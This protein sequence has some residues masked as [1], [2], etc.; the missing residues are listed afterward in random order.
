PP[1]DPKTHFSHCQIVFHVGHNLQYENF[2]PIEALATWLFGF[3]R[4][5]GLACPYRVEGQG[6]CS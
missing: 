6:F 1:A 5:T 4:R 2:K 3:S